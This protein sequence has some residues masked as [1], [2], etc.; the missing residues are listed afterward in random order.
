MG[1]KTGVEF[2]AEAM[3]FMK[4]SLIIGARFT[5]VPILPAN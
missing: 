4:I 3:V 2:V 1:K 5:S